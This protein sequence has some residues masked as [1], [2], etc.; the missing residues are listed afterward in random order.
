MNKNSATPKS[1][2]K[3]P[4]ENTCSYCLHFLPRPGTRRLLRG[5]CSFHK[6]WI[7]QASLTTCSDM[8]LRRLQ[9]AGIYQLEANDEGE[10]SY[11]R[12]KGKERTRLFLVHGG[13]DKRPKES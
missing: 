7:G 13:A 3:P 12:R 10:W 9:P 6:E 5:N 2:P 8:S 11:V 1:K 4:Q